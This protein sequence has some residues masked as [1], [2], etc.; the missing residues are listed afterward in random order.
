MME[1]LGKI[2]FQGEII[3]NKDISAIISFGKFLAI[4]SDENKRRV[5]ILEKQQG[6]V[7]RVRDDLEIQLPVLAEREDQEIDIEGM[8]INNGNTLFII[9]SHSLKRSKV[10]DD[11]TYLENRQRI[12]EVV[13]EDRR[14]SI[15]KLTIDPETGIANKEI[16]TIR[17]KEIIENDAVL[18]IFASIPSKEN[19]VDIEGI[20][21]DHDTVYIAFRGPV[22]RGN[23]APVMVLDLNDKSNYELR[24]I[25]L[26]GNGIRAITKVNDGFLIISGPVGDGFGPYQLYFWNGQDC[27]PGEGCP[28]NVQIQLIDDIPFPQGVE[29]AKAEGLTIIEEVREVNRCIYTAILV[30]D[31]VKNGGA[32]LFKFEKF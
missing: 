14:N 30:Y 23:Y 21:S 26:G 10:K 25:N 7:Y 6:N 1:N 2:E 4:G 20:A 24:F 19:G 11:K 15:F 29:D 3:E 27:I 8:S 13:V 9:G 31:G 5:Q 18:G 17:I 28:E 16:E 22:I 12:K 32:T